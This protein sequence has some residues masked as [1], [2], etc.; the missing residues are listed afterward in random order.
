MGKTLHIINTF[1]IVGLLIIS[2]ILL[3]KKFPST[4]DIAM[5]LPA[6][7][8]LWTFFI[9]FLIW[10]IFIILSFLKKDIDN[11]NYLISAV[12]N[13]ILAIIGLIISAIIFSLRNY[14]FNDEPLSYVLAFISEG[15]LALFLILSPF[16]FLISFIMFLVGY[17]KNKSTRDKIV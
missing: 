2:G 1:I 9:L 3:L 10:G 15:L 12:I 17:F 11:Q 4:L 13:T 14:Q 16:V 6:K 7:I 8:L 5:E